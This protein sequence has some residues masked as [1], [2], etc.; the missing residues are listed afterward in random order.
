M[1]WRNAFRRVLMI[2][3]IFAV[4]LAEAHFLPRYGYSIEW[5]LAGLAIT[6]VLASFGFE[7]IGTE[8][9]FVS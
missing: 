1:K 9:F 8:S 2:L 3:A 4:G 6:A 5:V 7:R